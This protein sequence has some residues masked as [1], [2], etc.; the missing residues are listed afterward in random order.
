MSYNAWRMVKRTRDHLGRLFLDG[1]RFHGE[2]E[3]PPLPQQIIMEDRL[4]GQFYLLSHAGGY[5]DLSVE[6]V[7]TSGDGGPDRVVY[8]SPDG[9][10][11]AG[12][13]FFILAE[14]LYTEPAPGVASAL[15]AT[16]R[17]K[18]SYG[19]FLTATISGAIQAVPFDV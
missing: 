2:P 6:L 4:D 19:L 11:S 1:N 10:V 5:P 14:E 16:R 12:W 17:D 13:R 15:V 8:T 9:P 3:I 18:D 7:A